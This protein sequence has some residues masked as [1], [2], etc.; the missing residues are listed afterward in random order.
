M[1][2]PPIFPILTDFGISFFSPENND[3][4]LSDN[5]EDYI[6]DSV[7]PTYPPVSY[8]TQPTPFFSY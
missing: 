1:Q 2:V 7:V 3:C 4:P 8:P 5:P 6:F